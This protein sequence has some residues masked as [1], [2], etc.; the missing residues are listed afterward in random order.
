MN[1]S[2]KSPKETKGVASCQSVSHV[3]PTRKTDTVLRMPNLYSEGHIS[4]EGGKYEKSNFYLTIGLWQSD[5]IFNVKMFV[6]RI[7]RIFKSAESV[8]WA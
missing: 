1:I 7:Y 2:T 5:F 3:G 6:I 4:W 8:I